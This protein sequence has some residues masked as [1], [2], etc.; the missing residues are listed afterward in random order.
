[1]ASLEE[2]TTSGDKIVLKSGEREFLVD[3]EV[4]MCSAMIRRNL[5][6]PH[7]SEHA[8][9]VPCITLDSI[10]PEVLQKVIEYMYYRHRYAQEDN[11]EP[12]PEFDCG[13][14]PMKVLSAAAFL[15]C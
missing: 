3:R 5:E 12:V 1:M 8:G 6:N 9:K 15:D 13:D 11:E 10:E 4:A 14:E 2:D 7:F